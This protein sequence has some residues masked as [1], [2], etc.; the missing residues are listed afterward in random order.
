MIVCGK[1]TFGDDTVGVA[2]LGVDTLSE[3][4]GTRNETFGEVRLE[5]I[6]GGV[7]EFTAALTAGVASGLVEVFTGV[8]DRVARGLTLISLGERLAALLTA[9]EGGVEIAEPNSL[10]LSSPSCSSYT[11]SCLDAASASFTI[12]SSNSRSVGASTSNALA[13]TFTGSDIAVSNTAAAAD[14]VE[15]GEAD[16][17][18]LL[19]TVGAT[20][21][22]AAVPGETNLCWAIGLV[23]M[24]LKGIETG[25]GEAALGDAAV[26]RTEGLG[27]RLS[28]P[29]GD[30]A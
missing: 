20:T 16:G 30:S 26:E 5:V 4:G 24:S 7:V 25:A 19:A 3:A 13:S 29:T 15:Y 21:R 8:V 11:A 14:L 23:L 27:L 2:D 18:T 22:D 1:A 9:T 28:D 12:M 6:L 10:L 17:R